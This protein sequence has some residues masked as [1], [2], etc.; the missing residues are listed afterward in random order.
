MYSVKFW[1]CLYLLIH[2]YF[3]QEDMDL[4]RLK[5]QLEVKGLVESG[6]W[7]SLDPKTHKLQALVWNT[8][9]SQSQ[10][11]LIATDRGRN[12]VEE[13]IEIRVVDRSDQ[14][15]ETHLFTLTLDN[16]HSEFEQSHSKQVELYKRINSAFPGSVVTIKS[17]KAGSIIVQMSLRYKDQ[18]S[19]PPPD[20]C[21]KEAIEGYQNTMFDGQ[22]I[23]KSFIDKFGSYTLK[24]VEFAP[25]GVCEGMFKGNTAT[26]M[27]KQPVKEDLDEGNTTP[28]IIGLVV[29]VVLIIIIVIVVIVCL[30]RR[31]AKKAREPLNG[32]GYIEKGVPVRLDEELKPLDKS[33]HQPLVTSAEVSYKPT[34]PAYPGEKQENDYQ[35][36][37]PPAS[38]PD[39]ERRILDRSP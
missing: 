22:E 39:D 17:V 25:L 6:G 33:E 15:Q 20:K 31:K 32:S 21:P 35:P 30:R 3:K 28:I 14:E 12:I 23:K 2:E 13:S 36:E 18:D 5:V 16:Q 38:I 8:P 9:D 26:L 34:P 10:F 24:I 4:S 7:V 1:S 27:N 19:M 37:T 29:A 11:S